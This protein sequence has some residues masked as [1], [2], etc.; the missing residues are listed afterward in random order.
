MSAKSFA[1][2]IKRE[3][4]EAKT[5][6]GKLRQQ[7]LELYPDLIFNRVNDI[8][9]INGL[10]SYESRQWSKYIIIASL[11][12]TNSIYSEELHNLDNLINGD[13]II[14]AEWFYKFAYSGLA[15]KQIGKLSRFQRDFRLRVL[16][17]LTQKLGNFV[18]TLEEK[19]ALCSYLL[20][21]NN[22]NKYKDMFAP[23]KLQA[24]KLIN[25][26]AHEHKIR[27]EDAETVLRTY[28]YC[29]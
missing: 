16:T 28:T 14:L 18:T 2:F 8:K 26:F 23:N 20:L 22:Y 6:I 11:Q 12:L 29:M 21:P 7:Y 19:E 24:F 4:E 27:Y 17:K 10:D 25:R 1:E 3:D 5:P 13:H 9:C 15:F